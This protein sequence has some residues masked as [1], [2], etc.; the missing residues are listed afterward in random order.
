MVWNG[1]MNKLNKLF[2]KFLDSIDKLKE[3]KKKYKE[4]DIDNGELFDIEYYS[5]E[6]E[7]EFIKCIQKIK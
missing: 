2:H 7:E 3:A 4:G 5:F 6:A 1:A